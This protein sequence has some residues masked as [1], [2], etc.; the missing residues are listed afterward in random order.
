M[1]ISEL[2]AELRR[3]RADY[4]DIEVAWCGSRPRDDFREQWEVDMD[5]TGRDAGK[6]HT[7][8]SVN[9]LAFSAGSRRLVE[10]PSPADSPNV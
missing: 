4:G 7:D 8:Y 2:M 9:V 10:V 3:A 6:G 5:V 1:K